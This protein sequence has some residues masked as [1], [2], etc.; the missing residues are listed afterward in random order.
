MAT[1]VTSAPLTYTLKESIELVGSER[2]S[3]FK[4]TVNG[5]IVEYSRI[6]RNIG[7]VQFWTVATFVASPLSSGSQF[8]IDEV[9]YIRITNLDDTNS[10]AVA[11]IPSI[12]NPVTIALRPGLTFMLG[13]PLGAITTDNALPTLPSGRDITAIQLRSMQTSPGE[14]VDVEVVVGSL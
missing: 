14:N 1:T 8:D 4:K 2:G 9:K 13:S 5:S 11:L 3:S 7:Y 12:G 10:L 6:V